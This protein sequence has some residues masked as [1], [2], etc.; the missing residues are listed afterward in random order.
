MDSN[1][2]V[3]VNAKD[4]YTNQLKSILTPP[5]YEKLVS[6]F[7]DAKNYQKSNNILRNFQYL[8]RD[9]KL[10]NQDIIDEETNRILSTTQCDYIDYLL[11][12]VFITNTK[13][14]TSVNIYNENNN[15]QI[16]VSIPNL[17]HFVHK[18][19]QEC[20]KKIFLNPSLFDD[21]LP[22]KERQ[23]NLRETIPIINSSIDEAIRELLPMKQLLLQYLDSDIKT[24]TDKPEESKVDQELN[25]NLDKEEKSHDEEEELSEEEV[26]EIEDE[27]LPE[28]EVNEIEKEDLPEE[29]VN[30]MEETLVNKPLEN[31][32]TK[33]NNKSLLS[34]KFGEQQDLYN[35]IMN[36]NTN[37]PTDDEEELDDQ[38]ED[39]SELQENTNE[40]LEESQNLVVEKPVHDE[41]E[42]KNINLQTNPIMKTKEVVVSKVNQED[43]EIFEKQKQ[44]NEN[45]DRDDQQEIER[46]NLEDQQFEMIKH[47]MNE[48]D[49]IQE[50]ITLDVQKSEK[51]EETSEQ[52]NN[53]LIL[54]EEELKTPNELSETTSTALESIEDITL[55]EMASEQ[56]IDESQNKNQELSLENT[57]PDDDSETKIEMVDKI[58]DLRKDLSNELDYEQLI[59][60]REENR[61]RKRNRLKKMRVR[62]GEMDNL[63]KYY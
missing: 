5:L 19:Y 47:K 18:C 14:L 13:I 25:N 62:K 2:N 29:E 59:R 44:H 39:I 61:D 32:I 27:E 21:S 16:E 41:P 57:V 35:E 30:E 45:M 53:N 48:E 31:I 11:K 26:N 10:W 3:L 6:I 50:N 33:P 63:M 37:V 60:R 22:A 34:D 28:E 9:I 7:D 12:A 15:K 4:S 51:T 49:K 1:I 20:A 56:S 38:Q 24:I 55:E 58:N 42:I 46:K 23:Q 8:L 36:S 52:E 43:I 54:E 17:S 40:N